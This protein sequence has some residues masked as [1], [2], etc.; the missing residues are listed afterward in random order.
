MAYDYEDGNL[1]VSIEDSGIPTPGRY[2]AKIELW[3]EGNEH[4]TFQY[5]EYGVSKQEALE[6]AKQWIIEYRAEIR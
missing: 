4:P 6:N 5:Y 2:V 1:K 3:I